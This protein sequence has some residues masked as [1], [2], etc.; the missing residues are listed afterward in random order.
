MEKETE[1]LIDKIKWTEV[2]MVELQKTEEYKQYE[3]VIR[4][5]GA[6]G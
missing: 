1:E 2:N 6:A 5:G 3:T 4:N